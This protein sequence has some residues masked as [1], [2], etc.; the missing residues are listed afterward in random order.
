MLILL[1]FCFC[2]C[3][4]IINFFTFFLFNYYPDYCYWCSQL[5]TAIECFSHYSDYERSCEAMRIFVLPKS[6]IIKQI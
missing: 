3:R 6:V 2:M 1:S 4:I 5:N